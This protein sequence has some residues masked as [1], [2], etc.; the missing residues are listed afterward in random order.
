MTAPIIPTTRKPWH[1][2]PWPWLLMVAPVAAV[3]GGAIMIWLAIASSDGLVADDYYKRGLA[4]N[5][6]LER[7]EQAQRMDLRADLLLDSASTQITAK[8]SSAGNRA[9]P[10]GLRLHFAHPAK[11]GLDQVIKLEPGSEGSYA[12]T[13]PRLAS[14]RWR[15]LLEDEHRTW[16]LAGEWR[17]EAPRAMLSAR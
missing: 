1:R 10:P 11:A 12:G 13:M 2:E 5:H 16:R 17:T 14:G 15:L 7:D 3:V 9:L 4:I 6:T 8:L